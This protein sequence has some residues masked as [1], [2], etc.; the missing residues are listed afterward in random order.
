MTFLNVE[1]KMEVVGS[2]T[3]IM[4]HLNDRNVKY[5]GEKPRSTL[6]LCLEFSSSIFPEKNWISL[7][8]TFETNLSIFQEFWSNVRVKWRLSLFNFL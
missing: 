7:N 5:Q 8:A 1:K 6:N 4:S 2:L 3:D